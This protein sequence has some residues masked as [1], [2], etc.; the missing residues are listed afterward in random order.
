MLQRLLDSSVQLTGGTVWAILLLAGLVVGILLI[1]ARVVISESRAVRWLKALAMIATIA[2]IAGSWRFK[3]PELVRVR[4]EAAQVPLLEK[5]TV[6]LIAANSSLMEEKQRLEQEV[7]K[8]KSLAQAA[9]TAVEKEMKELADKLGKF[10]KTEE[11]IARLTLP[12]DLVFA[13]GSAELACEHKEAL[14]KLVGYLLLETNLPFKDKLK[15]V[16]IVGNTDNQPKN[17][18]EYTNRVNFNQDLSE[19]RAKAVADYLASQ[20]VKVV[21]TPIG[22]GMMVPKLKKGDAQLSLGEIDRLNATADER[23]KNRRVELLFVRGQDEVPKQ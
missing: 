13:S 5:D 17:P 15:T 23:T 22:R 6:A 20:G 21:L 12:G 14:A 1:I 11:G 9:L 10:D 16:V 2:V 7:G 3:D 18:Q 4:A 8:Q 19:R